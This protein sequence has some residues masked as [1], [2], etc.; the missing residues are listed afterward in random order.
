[1]R[2]LFCGFA[3][4]FTSLC[5]LPLWAQAP[6]CTDANTSGGMGLTV[7]RTCTANPDA[8]LAEADA[9]YLVEVK[10]TPEAG[11]GDNS[12]FDKSSASGKAL[13]GFLKTFFNSE[14]STNLDI[15]L[16]IRQGS[17]VYPV[18]SLMNFQLTE[19]NIWR[20]SVRI[21]NRTMLHKLSAGSQFNAELNYSYSRTRRIDL[22]PAT[23]IVESFG[24]KLVTPAVAPILAT[25]RN[26]VN[27]TMKASGVDMQSGYNMDLAPWNGSTMEAE[28]L[29]TNPAGGK[30]ARVSVRIRGT[31][32]LMAAATDLMNIKNALPNGVVSVPLNAL[33][34]EVITGQARDWPLVNSALGASPS[35]TE[36][37]GK[38]LTKDTLLGFCQSIDTGISSAFLL[39]SFDSILMRA[40]LIEAS[41]VTI[42]PKINPYVR[43]FPDKATRD[44]ISLRLMINTEFSETPE[45]VIDTAK[46]KP[47]E[48][49][50]LAALGCVLKGIE[51]DDCGNI[52]ANREKVT[53]ALAPMVEIRALE[54]LPANLSTGL[55]ADYRIAPADF[56]SRFTRKLARFRN[57]SVVTQSMSVHE[58]LDSA[59]LRLKV[60]TDSTGKIIAIEFRNPT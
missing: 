17:D 23:A 5:A 38:E 26:V 50:A 34:K 40:K 43:C 32:S 7:T 18:M 12:T 49:E 44:V 9:Y 8:S 16:T 3:Y 6:N 21:N 41:T 4:L 20:S 13:K 28:F 48:Y 14:K 29:M 27:A 55:P 51:G 53:A 25:A 47:V 59:S 30:F 33:P 60:F 54:S 57:I 45:A 56:L 35:L 31:R 19:D 42:R 52:D 10:V 15:G 58:K 24:V 36:V 46:P 2:K 22:T 1:M 37:L 39:T 11:F